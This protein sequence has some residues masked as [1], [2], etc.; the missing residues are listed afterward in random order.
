MQVGDIYMKIIALTGGIGA[1]K[2]Q[3][4]KEFEKLG[5]F[6]LDADKISK[7]I[8]RKGASAYNETVAE[9]GNKILNKDN[10]INRKVL[11]DIVFNDKKKLARL[12]EI[13]HT[14]IY[15]DIKDRLSK[16]DAEVAC[17][18]IPLLFS[19]ECPLDISVKVLVV[20]P[21]ELRIE[22][23]IS[24]DNCKREQVLERMENQL[25][26]E[27][28]ARLTDFVIVNDGNTQELSDKVLGI[29]NRVLENN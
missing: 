28:M 9:F 20:A 6:V 21:T 29:Y 25:S 8:M 1:G 18:E 22:R 17:I 15:K 19:T 11:A 10:E 26:D 5:V 4:L 3:V 27:E 12:N 24:R 13:T 2:S 7:E 14:L 16:S 23:V